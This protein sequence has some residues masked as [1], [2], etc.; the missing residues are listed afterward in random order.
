MSGNEIP[1][2]LG[3]AS[4]SIA[5]AFTTSPSAISLIYDAMT[6]EWNNGGTAPTRMPSASFAILASPAARGRTVQLILRGYGTP[7][8]A[9][10]LDL[11][12]AGA[13][14]EFGRPGRI[15]RRR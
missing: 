7:P 14:I 10:S 11:K 8:G 12:V 5:G 3:L 13:P 9:G 4:A 2:L 15:M 1:Q 6:A